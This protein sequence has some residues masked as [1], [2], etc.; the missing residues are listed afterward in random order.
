VMVITLTIVSTNVN[1]TFFIMMFFLSVG[2]G[3]KKKANYDASVR[4]S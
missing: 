4:K 3:T 1:N 2:K